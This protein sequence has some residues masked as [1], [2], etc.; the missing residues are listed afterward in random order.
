MAYIEK[1]V[2]EDGIYI[3]YYIDNSIRKRHIYDFIELLEKH[4]NKLLK[5]VVSNC[6]YD[7]PHSYFEYFESTNNFHMH[8]LEGVYIDKF[9]AECKN[10]NSSFYLEIDLNDDCIRT[11]SNS[12]IDISPI[13]LEFEQIIEKK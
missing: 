9:N 2:D 4:G 6:N 3:K 1:K 7:D 5:I 8:M 12:P 13:V 10:K 11:F